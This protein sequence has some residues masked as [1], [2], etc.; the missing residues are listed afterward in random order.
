MKG[1]ELVTKKYISVTVII[2]G[3]SIIGGLI[4]RDIHILKVNS[5]I[6]VSCQKIFDSSFSD[7]FFK[8][9]CI[10]LNI[11]PLSVSGILFEDFVDQNAGTPPIAST[12]TPPPPPTAAAAIGQELLHPT[13]LFFASSLLK[14]KYCCCYFLTKVFVYKKFQSLYF[15]I[16]ICSK[17]P[18]SSHCRSCCHYTRACH[19]SKQRRT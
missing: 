1:N 13:I 17:S 16:T 7:F 19:R 15:I 14:C 12:T 2:S 11:E 3:C 4:F 6:S 9:I 18:G 5:C 10:K 8:Q